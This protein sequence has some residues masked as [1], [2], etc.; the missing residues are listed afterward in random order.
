VSRRTALGIGLG[1]WLLIDLPLALLVAGGWSPLL[2]TDRAV[3]DALQPAAVDSSA[4][5]TVLDVVSDAGTTWFRLLVL[6]LV[7]V[8]AFR[9][10]RARLG[11]YVAAVAALIG[12]VTTGLKLLVG[13][14]RPEFP[15]P[16]YL[17][18]TLSHPSGHAS[19]I[20]TLVGLLLVAFVRLLPLRWR[21]ATVLGG[22]ALVFAVGLTRI[23]LGAH[24]PSDVVAGFA[25]GAGW[26]LVVGAA[27][28]VL[29]GPRREQVESGRSLS[30]QPPGG[31]RGSDDHR[32]TT[33]L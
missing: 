8:W 9:T 25:L 14:D 17:G 27:W 22:V 23:G 7:V 15:D 5:R 16:V 1:L 12:P 18:D 2:R 19:G 29:P 20:V 4:Y 31:E 30:P 13:R 11:W 24:Y 32:R 3:V 21:V 33:Q 10:G 6:V 26:V 28:D